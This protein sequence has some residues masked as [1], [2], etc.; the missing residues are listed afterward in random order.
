[1]AFALPV[2][3]FF[4]GLP[5]WFVAICTYIIARIVMEKFARRAVLAVVPAEEG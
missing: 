2:E 3:L 1:V 4:K 5:G